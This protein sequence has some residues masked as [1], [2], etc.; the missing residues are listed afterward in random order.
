MIHN[1]VHQK[2]VDASDRQCWDEESQILHLCG[3]LFACISGGV[4]PTMLEW[5]EYLKDIIEEED[6]QNPDLQE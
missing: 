6:A 4:T 2:L 5:E 1:D 3:F